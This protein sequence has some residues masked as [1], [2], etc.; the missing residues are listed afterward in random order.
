[1]SFQTSS[2]EEAAGPS[3][4]DSHRVKRRRQDGLANGFNSSESPKTYPTRSLSLAPRYHRHVDKQMDA[5]PTTLTLIGA[6]GDT[7]RKFV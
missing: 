6:S 1:M 5:Q 7:V 4:Y 2:V 3:S